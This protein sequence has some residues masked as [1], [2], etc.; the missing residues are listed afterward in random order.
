MSKT[1]VY[2]ATWISGGD[3]KDY[4]F[5]LSPKKPSSPNVRG[6]VFNQQ[7]YTAY[8]TNRIRNDRLAT[9][10]L[11]CKVDPDSQRETEL[12]EYLA[13]LFQQARMSRDSKAALSIAVKVTTPIRTYLRIIS[14]T[15]LFGSIYSTIDISRKPQ[16]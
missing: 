15:V 9:A 11:L 8:A 16:P 4:G 5:I 6:Y 14:L 13:M 7:S 3:K 12:K 10:V 2:L 1:R